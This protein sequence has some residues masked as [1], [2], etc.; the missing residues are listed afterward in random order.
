MGSS[1]ILYCRKI[2]DGNFALTVEI[3][4]QYIPAGKFGIS[5]QHVS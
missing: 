3:F 5:G 1:I 2:T 4:L